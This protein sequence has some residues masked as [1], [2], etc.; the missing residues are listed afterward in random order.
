MDKPESYVMEFGEQLN[1]QTM[2]KESVIKI[3]ITQDQYGLI[4]SLANVE[5][6]VNLNKVYVINALRFKITPHFTTDKQPL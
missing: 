4:E 3:V 1:L 2:Q 6:D 5:I